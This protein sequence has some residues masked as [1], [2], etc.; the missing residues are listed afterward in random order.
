MWRFRKRWIFSAIILLT[1]VSLLFSHWAAYHIEEANFYLL[2][3][4]AW[5]LGIGACIAFVFLYN[6]QFV[7]KLRDQ[8]I[9]AES[10]SVLGI[11][12][13]FYSI[14]AFDEHT[15][16]PSFYSLIP[17]VGAGLIIIFST[18]MTFVGKMLSSKPFIYVGLVSYSAYLWHQPIFSFARHMSFPEPDKMLF[19]ILIVLTFILSY[20]SWKYVEKPFRSKNKIGIKVLVNFSLLGSVLFIS[21]GTAGHLS[22]GFKSRSLYQNLQAENYQPDYE[23]LQAESW[24]LLR[25]LSHNKKYA[26]EDNVFDREL[27]FDLDR[28]KPKLLLVGNSHSK[29]MFNVLVNSHDASSNYQIARFGG[30][31]ASMDDLFDSPNYQHA[32]IV[33]VASKYRMDDLDNLEVFVRRIENDNKLVVIVKNV[34]EFSFHANKNMADYLLQHNYLEKYIDGDMS[35]STIVEEVDKKYYEEYKTRENEEIARKS[36]I[37]IDNLKEKYE[38][39]VVLDRMDYICNHSAGRCFSLNEKLEKYFYDYGHH[40]LKGAEFFGKRVDEIDWLKDITLATQ[41]LSKE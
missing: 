24:N 36:N 25:Q 16:F 17:T 7:E 41:S 22:D 6:Y 39:L 27:W 35:T 26:V 9:F 14:I 12:F 11:I 21:I 31:I 3:T 30:Q 32:D 4:R 8:K 37:L 20:L 13:I 38:N 19:V 5:E 28:K 33:V 15:P 1:G 29:D 10:L 23:V 2:P 34:Y 18:H 40:T